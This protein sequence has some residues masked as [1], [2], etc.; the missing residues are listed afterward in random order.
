MNQGIPE[1]R[2]PRDH[3]DKEIEQIRMLGVD[4]QC[5][6]EIG[7]DVEF[8][9]LVDDYDAIVMAAGTLRPNVLDLPGKE[10]KGIKH[11]LD[12]LLEVNETDKSD[13]GKD[14]IVIGGGFTAMDCARTAK[15][16]GQLQAEEVVGCCHY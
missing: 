12:F 1:F 8:S 11:G 5:P 9:Q 7:K 14:V 6:V 16:L 10:L 15:R 13:I 2:L 3:I 4:I